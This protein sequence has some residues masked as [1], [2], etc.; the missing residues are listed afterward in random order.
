MRVVGTVLGLVLALGGGYFLLQRS[1]GGPGQQPPQVQINVVGA[2]QQLLAIAQ[3]ERR[4]L[5]AH[6]H[7]GTLEELA[8]DDLMPGGAA[9][10]G[11]TLSATTN[12]SQGFTITATPTDATSMGSPTLEI[13][14]T[15]AIT[16]R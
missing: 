7:Y 1:T 14:E 10:R 11:Y 15:M 9:P 16:E 4:Y 5:V 3:A 8:Q 12:G 6:G 13:T 2:R